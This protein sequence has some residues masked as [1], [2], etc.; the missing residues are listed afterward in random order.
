MPTFITLGNF[1]DQGIKNIKDTAKRAEAFN[2]LAEVSS[3]SDK[4]RFIVW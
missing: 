1:T 3:P 2:A 4:I